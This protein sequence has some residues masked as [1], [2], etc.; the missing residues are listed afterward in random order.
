MFDERLMIYRC[1]RSNTEGDRFDDLCLN[2]LVMSTKVS[3]RRRLRRLRMDLTLHSLLE[4][5]TNHEMD[6]GE[7]VDQYR[8]AVEACI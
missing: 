1:A 6:S 2:D 7:P 8:G 5:G 4:R 3:A